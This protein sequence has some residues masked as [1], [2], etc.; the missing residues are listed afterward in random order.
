V[1]YTGDVKVGGPADTREL[2]ALS[3]S[4]AAVGDMNNNA[5]LLT[6]RRTNERVLIDAAAEP[7]RL[8]ELIGTDGLSGVITTHGHRDH[9]QALSA[10]AEATS[11]TRFAH[12]DDADEIGVETDVFVSN[13]DRIQVGELTLEVISIRGHTPGSVALLYDDPEGAAH[14]F[15]GDS[16]FPGG[17][18]NTDHDSGRFQS[19]MADLEQRVFARLPDDT[20][21]Y[22]GHGADTTLAAERPSLPQW[23]ARGW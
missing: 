15:T 1:T 16:L 22:P 20:W 14:L 8:L 3:I 5:Y 19:L 18:G 9:W 6:C 12:P 17:P 10:V 21:V 23:R 13:G 7:A 11:A 2:D 4:K